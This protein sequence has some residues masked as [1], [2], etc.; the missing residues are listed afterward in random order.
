MA[1]GKGAT[2]HQRRDDGRPGQL[3][4]DA[5]CLRTASLEDASPDIEDGALRPADELGGGRYRLGIGLVSGKIAGQVD[6]ARVVPVH[7][8]V[9]DVLRNV[10]EHRPRPPGCRHMK[11][12][13]DHLRNVVGR[14]DEPVVFRDA[15]RD[16]RRVALLERVGPDR[17]PRHLSRDDDQRDRVHVGVGERRD[18]V[19]GTR[20]A[21]HHRHPRPPGHVGIT[22]RCMARPLLVADEDVTDRRVE[23]RVVDGEDGAA[24]EAE[25][26]LHS[27][28]FQAPYE[29]LSPGVLHCVLPRSVVAR[30]AL[31]GSRGLG[32]PGALA[33]PI[34]TVAGH[35]PRPGTGNTAS[36]NQN[37]LPRGEVESAR[38]TESRVRYMRITTRSVRVIACQC[39]RGTS[40]L[41]TC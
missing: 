33:P 30:L 23:D 20:P 1:V 27:F 9:G 25:D 29:G 4:Q 12:L 19:R 21:R 40:L 31:L 22:L 8:R 37:D 26:H 24:G 3:G 32:S 14:G 6:L 15:H 18:D 10:D 41:A 2:R 35:R 28:G 5:Q 38:T 16:A 13:V 39:G 36:R 34:R 7:E 17:C 11:G